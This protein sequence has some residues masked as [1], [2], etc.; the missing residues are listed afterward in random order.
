MSENGKKITY[1]KGICP[2]AE[3]LH[4]ESLIMFEVCLF[5]LSN[6]D[7]DLIIEVFKKVWKNLDKL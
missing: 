1:K 5:E 3:K 6:S 7:V 2:I 4:D